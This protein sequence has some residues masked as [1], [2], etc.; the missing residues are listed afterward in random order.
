MISVIMG[1]ISDLPKMQA[2]LDL[3]QEYNV[4]Y[5]VKIMSAHRTP[6]EMVEYA[7]N[8]HNRGVKII[9]AGAGGAAH[10]PGMIASLTILPVIGIPISL[11]N[12]NGMDSLLSIVQMPKGVPVA[13]M[14]I[15]NSYNG[16]ITAM[17]IMAL[18]DKDLAE[19]L[20]Q[21][22]LDLKSKVHEMNK[23]LTKL[24]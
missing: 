22:R 24:I 2:G 23:E 19:K 12:L 11:N 10:L 20:N 8:A 17:R 9:I 13:T 4:Q 5:E 18:S 15:D 3:L 14:A 7:K 6:E 21:L 16:A 1:S